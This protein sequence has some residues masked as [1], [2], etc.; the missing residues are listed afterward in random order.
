MLQTTYA[1]CQ[2]SGWTSWSREGPDGSQPAHLEVEAE[3][4]LV[5]EE[6]VA[7]RRG[8]HVAAQRRGGR[9][10]AAQHCGRPVHDLLHVAAHAVQRQ[11]VCHL[12]TAQG[13]RLALLMHCSISIA[14][15]TQSGLC[16]RLGQADT[17]VEPSTWCLLKCRIPPFSGMRHACQRRDTSMIAKAQQ[18]CSLLS[19]VFTLGYGL[20]P[21]DDSWPWRLALSTKMKEAPSECW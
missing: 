9:A 2:L 15:P 1:A 16:T 10:A 20:L 11:I 19:S 4:G 18:V 21:C 7:A 14:W 8:D 12:R 6:A 13:S 5:G 17:S 3:E